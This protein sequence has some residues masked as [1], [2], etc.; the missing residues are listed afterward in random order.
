VF[1]IKEVYLKGYTRLKNNGINELHYTPNERLQFIIGSNGSGKSSLINMLIP[2]VPTSTVFTDDGIYTL[3]VERDGK[4]YR[5]EY[6]KSPKPTFS[7][8]IDG[9]ENLNEG[10]TG[11]VQK[12]LIEYYINI[13]QDIVGVLLGTDRFTSMTPSR[14]KY[15]MSRLSPT[16]V[17]TIISAYTKTNEKIKSTT[18]NIQFL[19]KKILQ[20]TEALQKLGDDNGTSD[21]SNL[22]SELLDKLYPLKSKIANLTPLDVLSD[23]VDKVATTYIDTTERY[24]PTID[25]NGTITH[26]SDSVAIDE[27]IVYATKEYELAKQS[28]LIKAEELTH[29]TDQ[30][31]TQESMGSLETLNQKLNVERLKYSE[32]KNL[33]QR[34]FNNESIEDYHGFDA[35]LA[36]DTLL[37]NHGALLNE[38]VYILDNLK[39]DSDGVI[40]KEVLLD[41]EKYLEKLFSDKAL[42]ES[43]IAQAKNIIIGCNN[44]EHISCKRCGNEWKMGY[45][46]EEVTR[47]KDTIAKKASILT[48]LEIMKYAK[49]QC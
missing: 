14:R 25:I 15:W 31:S 1:I 41:K 28:Y 21:K 46:D 7:F 48:Y 22:V 8:H 49:N 42:L 11:T 43:E 17:E 16:S 29:L 36:K 10:G 45:T 5:L 18:N 26:I 3:V 35:E 19:Q 37:M 4:E 44:A 24:I 20:A 27:A 40:T 9:G 6:N 32:I 30:I 34:D 39:S 2:H 38:I 13:E 12:K 23:S 33:F 47:A